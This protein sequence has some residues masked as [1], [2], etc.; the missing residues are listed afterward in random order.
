MAVVQSPLMGEMSGKVANFVTSTCGKQNVVRTKAFKPKNAN[1]ESQKFVRKSFKLIITE[2]KSW[3][4][5]ISLGFAEVPE[6][7]TASNMF[8]AQNVSKAIVKSGD[9]PVI[10]YS[11]LT[12]A[13]GSLP[14]V[15]VSEAVIVA[16]GISISYRSTSGVPSIKATDEM[17]AVAKT[18]AGEIL[19][20]KQARGSES[21]ATIL[22]SYPGIKAS[23]IQCCYVF[24]RNADGSKSSKSVHIPFATLPHI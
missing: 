16:D 7:K 2:D 21:E 5:I 14:V 19:I 10:D 20:C 15:I 22:I 17:M 8:M 1:T 23:D 6:G 11:L 4:G 9:E 12:V 3:G 13:N 18:K 24:V